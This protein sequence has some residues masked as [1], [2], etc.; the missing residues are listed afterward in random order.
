ML[1]LKLHTAKIKTIKLVN[2]QQLQATNALK[3]M[4]ILINHAAIAIA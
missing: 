3:T 4:R 2:A 1:L